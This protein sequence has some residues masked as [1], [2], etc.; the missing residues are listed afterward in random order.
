MATSDDTLTVVSIAALAFVI[1]DLAHEGVGHGFGFYFAGGHSCMLTTTRLIA[2]ITLPDPQWRMFDL[3]RS[4]RQSPLCDAVPGS[5]CAFFA[6]RPVQ[7]EI[8]PLA[9]HGLQSLLGVRLSDFLRRNWAAA[10]GWRLSRERGFSSSAALL[11]VLDSA[12]ALSI[13]DSASCRGIA[14]DLPGRGSTHAE[15]ARVSRLI[16]LSYIFGGVIACAGAALDPSGRHRDSQVRRLKQFWRGR[17]PFAHRS[18]SFPL[19]PKI[20]T[21]QPMP[22]SRHLAW[23]LAA[24]AACLY[25][26]A[27]LGPGILMYLGN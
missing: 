22:V 6:Q 20:K 17:W 21:L 3:R 8:F 12:F 2:W 5:A 23:I 24:A 9:G 25:Y 13:L 27:I 1:A 11:F 15:S 7:L 26:I 4:G 18:Q 19:R 14:Q 10:I 16:W